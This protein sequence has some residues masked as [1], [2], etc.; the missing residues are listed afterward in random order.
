MRDLIDKSGMTI[1]EVCALLGCSR[2]T[3]YR[4]LKGQEP[5]ERFKRILYRHVHGRDLESILPL[6]RERWH[7]LPPNVRDAIRCLVDN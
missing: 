5:S 4:W 2:Q 3:V 1:T 6:L 7:R